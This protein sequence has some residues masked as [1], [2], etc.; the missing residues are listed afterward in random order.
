[1]DKNSYSKLYA[2]V[3]Q[4]KPRE[5]YNY[6]NLEVQWGYFYFSHNNLIK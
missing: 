5:Y 1:M 6:E 2:D 4:N 3:N